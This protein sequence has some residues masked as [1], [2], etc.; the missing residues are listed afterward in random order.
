MVKGKSVLAAAVVAASLG[1]FAGTSHALVYTEPT[2][3]AGQTLATAANAG[4]ATE[5]DG[6]LSNQFDAD[7][8][9][10]T[11]STTG[12]YTF[13][14][15]NTFT[16]NA[17]TDT[18]L[19]LFT[20]TGTA[21]LLNDDASGMVI[22]ST[23]TGTLTAGTYYVGVASSGNEPVNSNSQLL[24]AEPTGASS[25]DTTVVRSPAMGVNPT[26]LANFNSGNTYYDGSGPY[27]IIITAPAAVP[28]P[29]TWAVVG[30]SCAALALLRR[31]RVA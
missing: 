29:S 19:S 20:S 22:T 1:A 8:Y 30:A 25:G 7:L 15:N 9:K 27:H 24:F 16:N 3:D 12:S 5:I 11:L 26:T 21:L 2:S 6:T 23:I 4:A 18:E 31:R 17:G 13:S 28:E 14:T 10:I